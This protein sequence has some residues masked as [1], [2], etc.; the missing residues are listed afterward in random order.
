MYYN[1]SD[2]LHA[3][4]LRQVLH[5]TALTED[6]AVGIEDFLQS[7]KEGTPLNGD[8]P[9]R[10]VCVQGD[11][12]TGKT[13][14]VVSLC[15]MLTCPIVLGS[16]NPSSVNVAERCR[17]AFP[18]SS[19]V[20]TQLSG[21][22][23]AGMHWNIGTE[24]IG[25][26]QEDELYSLYSECVGTRTPPTDTQDKQIYTI[27]NKVLLRKMREKFENECQMY[28]QSTIYEAWNSA[29]NETGYFPA[30]QRAMRELHEMFC[31]IPQH[32]ITQE[33]FNTALAFRCMT[34]FRE[35]LPRPLLT[36]FLILEEAARLPA[37]FLR[38]MAYYHYMVRFHLKPPGYR[39]TMLTICLM[40]SPLQSTVIA[41]P[42]FSVMDEAV[43]DAEKRH[44][45]ISVYTVNRRTPVTSAKAKA[46]AT[47][48]HVLEND[49]VLKQEH[50]KLL[51][52]FLVNESSF[53]DPTFARSAMRLTH[54]H[55]RVV[56]FTDKANS[57][58]T[59]VITFYEHLLVSE[60]VL[61]KSS[62]RNSTVIQFL[63][64]KGPACL[65]YRST[66]AK[67]IRNEGV[68]ETSQPI[69]VDLSEKL[70]FSYKLF[71]FKRIL[72]RDTPVS[73]QHSTRLVPVEYHGTYS[74]FYN[75]SALNL[76][77]NE[78][79]WS[80]RIGISFAT[81]LLGDSNLSESEVCYLAIAIDDVWD[82]ACRY[83]KEIHVTTFNDVE[84][85]AAISAGITE[86][87]DYL[88]QAVVHVDKC[89]FLDRTLE[90]QPFLCETQL[91]RFPEPFVSGDRF[92]NTLTLE[93]TVQVDALD[94]TEKRMKRGQMGQ[95][96][97]K[98]F[99]QIVNELSRAVGNNQLLMHDL[100]L[101][102]SSGILFKTVNLLTL[103]RFSEVFPKDQFRLESVADSDD[104]CQAPKAKKA[105]STK[106]D[107]KQRKLNIH[108][109]KV[110]ISEMDSCKAING[111]SDD[112]QD[113]DEEE[114]EE[115]DIN[116]Q[117]D[118]DDNDDD[119][120]EPSNQ[121]ATS[122]IHMVHTVYDSRVRTID[123]V[124]GE[125]ITCGTLVD[126]QSIQTMGQLTVA[127]TRNTDADRLM[128]TSNDIIR[129]PLRDPITKLVRLSARD[130]HCYYV[131]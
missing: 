12:G 59:K 22:A 76:S 109:R 125:T 106:R 32:E 15:Q 45:H 116:D 117:H 8:L 34:A 74:S 4:R 100:L 105:K 20:Q 111:N 29:R 11:A 102:A 56:D 83:A 61:H 103:E 66:R 60:S 28:P 128:L 37:Y 82:I 46:L 131:K 19:S 115:Y 39:K 51:E 98:L 94:I 89:G 114:E 26:K 40:G 10:I 97:I 123:S 120:D 127:L 52:P 78:Q 86:A 101:R 84:Q 41:F 9:Y 49:C 73:I 122:I 93:D 55:K 81:A 95:F 21:T 77:C 33:D 47:V 24:K 129:I 30:K 75:S 96:K 87:H 25:K 6:K 88:W 68:Q 64:R 112:C 18:Y 79:L 16:T 7:M 91:K 63:A 43:L 35:T 42:D 50:C 85:R 3:A 107:M 121:E 113:D 104:D 54:Y 80:L 48:V 57:L 72:G 36:N 5:D 44:T 23:W 2:S 70:S 92:S 38:I 62:D 99:Y 27:L 126:V 118:N 67:D 108:V 110:G 53:M 1:I 58:E 13:Q 90:I 31:S 17:S 14:A 119:D 124:Q 130:R 69:V 65:P 71:S